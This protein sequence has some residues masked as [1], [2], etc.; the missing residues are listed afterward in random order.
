MLR[1]TITVSLHIEPIVK[2]IFIQNNQLMSVSNVCGGHLM[3]Q[4]QSA[5]EVCTKRWGIS[6]VKNYHHVSQQATNAAPHPPSSSLRTEKEDLNTSVMLCP[7]P[8]MLPD[9]PRHTRLVHDRRGGCFWLRS[10]S[11]P[12]RLVHSLCVLDVRFLRDAGDLRCCFWLSRV[13]RSL[14]RLCDVLLRRRRDH[15]TRSVLCWYSTCRWARCS[16]CSSDWCI[17]SCRLVSTLRP[18]PAWKTTCPCSGRTLVVE[19]RSRLDHTSAAAS[20][21]ALR[22]LCRDFGSSRCTGRYWRDRCGCT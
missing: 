19:N 21:A 5:K 15:R 4:N 2:R 11:H 9:V 3:C 12:L 6:E 20:G 13:H 14:R 7:P 8:P 10:N 22:A 16:C 17:S 1:S 18:V